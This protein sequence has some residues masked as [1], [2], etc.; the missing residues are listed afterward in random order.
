MFSVVFLFGVAYAR[1][2]YSGK[3]SRDL[4]SLLWQADPVISIIHQE[5]NCDQGEWTEFDSG[6]K[7]KGLP[8]KM[9]GL[10]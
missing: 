8:R 5:R 6:V 1:R 9:P 4:L 3:M 7:F 10:P 2:N